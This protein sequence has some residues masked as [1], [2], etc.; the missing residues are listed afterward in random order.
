MDEP[1]VSSERSRRQ[2]PFPVSAVESQRKKESSLSPVENMASRSAPPDTEERVRCPMG[3]PSGVWVTSQ[4]SEQPN[5]IPST[6][7]VCFANTSPTPAASRCHARSKVA[8]VVVGSGG[9]VGGVAPE[10]GCP[11]KPTWTRKPC[12]A[13]PTLTVCIVASGLEGESA[14]A[15]CALLRRLRDTA[16]PLTLK[17]SGFSLSKVTSRERSGSALVWVGVAQT[18]SRVATVQRTKHI[19]VLSTAQNAASVLESS[20][21]KGVGPLKTRQ[22]LCLC[23]GPSGGGAQGSPVGIL[24]RAVQAV[25]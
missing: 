22:M 4:A 16:S 3:C 7:Q 12:E 24:G 2:R 6:G 20:R 10:V 1:W 25:P 8:G 14:S 5:A 23:W 17:A 21:A 13:S 11:W 15:G 18:C 19:W 9:G